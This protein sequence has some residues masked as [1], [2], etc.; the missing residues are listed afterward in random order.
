MNDEGFYS[1]MNIL[2]SFVNHNNILSKYRDDETRDRLYHFLNDVAV[3]LLR[4]QKNWAPASMGILPVRVMDEIM[5]L[6]ENL[7]T[8]TIFRARDGEDRDTIRKA[9]SY[10]EQNVKTEEVGKEKKFLGII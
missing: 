1:L 3:L 9:G 7:A 2:F 4:N 6:I 10:I 8:A 5:V